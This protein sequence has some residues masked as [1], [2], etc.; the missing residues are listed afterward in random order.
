MI[1]VYGCEVE[2]SG[3]HLTNMK[4]ERKLEDNSDKLII[5]RN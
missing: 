3:V 1:L 2:K 5:I 4:E